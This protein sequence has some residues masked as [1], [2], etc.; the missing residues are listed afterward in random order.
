MKICG[1]YLLVHIESGRKYAA[2]PQMKAKL[3]AGI[4]RYWAERHAQKERTDA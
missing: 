1:I 3:A 2:D 4:Q